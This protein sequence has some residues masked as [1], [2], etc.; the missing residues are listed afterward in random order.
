MS[1]FRSPD[2]PRP[3]TFSENL[4]RANDAL[5]ERVRVVFRPTKA[6]RSRPYRVELDGKDKAGFPSIEGALFAAL[7]HAKAYDA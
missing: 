5:P 7:R 2:T 3:P 4:R 1:L 6:F